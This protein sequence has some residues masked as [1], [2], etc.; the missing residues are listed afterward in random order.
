MYEFLKKLFG[1]DADGKPV[2][3]T[4]EQLA[5]KIG[6]DKSLKIVNLADGGYV[7]QDKYQAEVTKNTGLSQQLEAANTTIQSYKDM[8]I[9]GIKKSAADWET[10]YKQDTEALQAQLD[11]QARSHGEDMFFRDYKFSSK[12]AAAGVR[13]EFAKK[14]F[15]L[16]DG[17][18]VGAKEWMDELAKDEDYKSAFAVETPP[19]PPAGSSGKKPPKFSDP[20]PQGG[21]PAGRKSLTELMKMKN[22]NPDAQISYE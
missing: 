19:A 12:A 8:D 13:A 15:E 3:L 18:F 21:P 20:K 16:K 2:A 10:K 11:A 22:D 1:T 5:E 6:A 14:N 4:Y 7:S 17:T 9:D